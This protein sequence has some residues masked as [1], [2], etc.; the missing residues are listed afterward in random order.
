MRL[1]STLYIIAAIDRSGVNVTM[2]L[3]T[4]TYQF[5][6]WRISNMESALMKNKLYLCIYTIYF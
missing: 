2:L 4:Y 5:F 1:C 6:K 3:C